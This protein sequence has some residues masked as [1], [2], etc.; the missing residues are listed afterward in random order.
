MAYAVEI[1][2]IFEPA[3]T[4]KNPSDLINVILPNLY[5]LAGIIVFIL[6]LG[7][8]FMMIQG[9]SSGDAQQ[10]GRGKQAVTYAII[11]LVIIF[12]SF[13]FIKFI[14]GLVGVGII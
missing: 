14:G 13:F 2:K 7:G 8:G 9:A 3:K 11:G 5:L 12:G 4:F 1:D 10:T 6:F